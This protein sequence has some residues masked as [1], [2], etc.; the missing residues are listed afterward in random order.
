M[1]ELRSKISGHYKGLIFC[2]SFQQAEAVQQALNLYL[3]EAFSA[4]PTSKIKRGCSEYPLKF[5]NY[6]EI[7]GNFNKLMTF[8]REW[9]VLEEKFD[10]RE[11]IIPQ[12]NQKASL[13]EY[14][15][16][17][18]YIIQ[19][20]IDYAKGIGDTSIEIFK[21]RPIIFKEIYEIAKDRKG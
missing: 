7:S 14:C 12:E 19:K 10:R 15:I 11:L 8:P 2:S 6:G 16:S 3:K 20:W 21:D 9:K 13:T 5:P 4:K 17:D 18:F 1:V